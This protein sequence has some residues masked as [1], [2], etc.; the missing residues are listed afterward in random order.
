[1]LPAQRTPLL[2][3]SFFQTPLLPSSILSLCLSVS[4]S[5]LLPS[6]TCPIPSPAFVYI[7][8][9]VHIP[10]PVRFR[11]CD[12]RTAV[13][14]QRRTAV[15]LQRTHG[16]RAEHTGHGGRAAPVLRV[17]GRHFAAVGYRE[18]KMRASLEGPHCGV[19]VRFVRRRPT[20]KSTQTV[21]ACV[22]FP[23]IN[24]SLD[25]KGAQGGDRQQASVHG[26]LGPHDQSL[27]PGRR[28][29]S[30]NPRVPLGHRLH[31]GKRTRTTSSLFSSNR[32]F[33]DLSS[34]ITC[35]AA[36]AG[37]RSDRRIAAAYLRVGHEDRPRD[38]VRS[39]LCRRF[40]H[41]L[42]RFKLSHEV[43]TARTRDA[44]SSSV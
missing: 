2:R 37:R 23:A 24:L 30:A 27:G 21:P 31:A 42:L 5:E 8:V 43:T 13:E 34:K 32:F 41:A 10:I 19:P 16:G 29:R 28:P 39:R 22:L 38:L 35:G 20:S 11:S 6:V 3:Y 12:I 15:D 1:M 33:S 26:Q 14:P 7:P 4:V 36:G 44:H 25:S 17:S 18:R 9:P 40:L